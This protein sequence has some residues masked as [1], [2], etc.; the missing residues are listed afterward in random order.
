MLRYMYMHD[1]NS[2]H[3]TI[4]CMHSMCCCKYSKPHC[5]LI[6]AFLSFSLLPVDLRPSYSFSSSHFLSRSLFP[7]SP[8]MPPFIPPTTTLAVSTSSFIYSIVIIISLPLDSPSFPFLSL[9][10][11]F[12]ISILSFHYLSFPSIPRSFSALAF[13]ISSLASKSLITSFI[14]LFPFTIIGAFSCLSPS[15]STIFIVFSVSLIL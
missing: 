4:I 5:I 15:N 13:L 10:S 3:E 8:L 11:S 12:L 14:C 2:F 7:Q 9:S 6:D 1:L